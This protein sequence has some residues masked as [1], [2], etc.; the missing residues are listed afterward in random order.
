MSSDFV[1]GRL[2]CNESDSVV[3]SRVNQRY[4]QRSSSASIEDSELEVSFGVGVQ[5]N[6]ANGAC[7]GGITTRHNF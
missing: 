2:Q 1:Q 5:E 6:D 3:S 4:E 7:K